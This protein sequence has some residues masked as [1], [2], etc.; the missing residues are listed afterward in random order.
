MRRIRRP[1]LAECGESARQSASKDSYPF[2]ERVVRTFGSLGR[3][4]RVAEADRRAVRARSSS[5]ATVAAARA[6][7]SAIRV[8]CQP[9]MPATMTVCTWAG[10]W[11]GATAAGGP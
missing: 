1:V 8:I 11:A 10:T 9:A 5:T 3:Q 7:A 2:P 6:A 4:V